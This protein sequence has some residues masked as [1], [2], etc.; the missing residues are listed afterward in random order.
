MDT[1]QRILL[2]YF[3]VR[4]AAARDPRIRAPIEIA[5][6]RENGVRCF[7]GEQLSEV[8]RRSEEIV[9]QIAGA[10]HGPAPMIPGL[11]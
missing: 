7:S 2:A 3:C 9:A 5:V 10:F 11:K 1:G 6:V 8:E 4:E